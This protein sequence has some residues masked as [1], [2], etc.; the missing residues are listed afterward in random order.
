MKIAMKQRGRADNTSGS[1]QSAK[2]V[3]LF[4]PMPLR[5]SGSRSQ[6][7]TNHYLQR[8]KMYLSGLG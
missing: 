6:R 8:E 3:V 4:N 2:H 5:H 1:V 7:T